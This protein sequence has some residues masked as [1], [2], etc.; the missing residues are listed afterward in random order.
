[1][2]ENTDI[3]QGI[4][5]LSDHGL[6]VKI[7]DNTTYQAAAEILLLHKDMQKK[8]EAYFKPLKGAAHTSW[9]QIVAAESAELDKLI[10]VETYLK[11]EIGRYQA[12][13]EQSR[14][15]AEN[16]LRLEA[17]KAEEERRLAAAVQAEAEGYKD[18]AAEILETPVF[19]PMPTLTKT[20]PAI[21]GLVAKTVWKFRVTNEALVPRQYLILNETA[22]R[23]VVTALKDK[24]NIP[25]VEVYQESGIAA[26]R[27]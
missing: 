8:I 10:P 18:E 11:K 1:M 3:E 23:I 21:K 22:I 19:V 26:G 5:T 25:G 12:E 15:A 13:Q 2:L 7:V 27:R 17:M 20:V 9:K 4:I 6:R 16:R 14:R 24:A